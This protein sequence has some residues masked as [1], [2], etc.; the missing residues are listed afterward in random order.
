M[1]GKKKKEDFSEQ[2]K[3]GNIVRD[4]RVKKSSWKGG[5]KSTIK[6]F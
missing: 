3:A 5:G 2:G 1:V 6:T 4:Y